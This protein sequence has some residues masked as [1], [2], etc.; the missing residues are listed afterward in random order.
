MNRHV[1]RRRWSLCSTS[2]FFPPPGSGRDPEPSRCQGWRLQWCA[3]RYQTKGRGFTTSN[4][5]RSAGLPTAS[6]SKRLNR[7]SGRSCRRGRASRPHRQRR[8]SRRTARQGLRRRRRSVP[9]AQI[10]CL[11]NFAEGVGAHGC[12]HLWG[13]PCCGRLPPNLCCFVLF[14]AGRF[15]VGSAAEPRPPHSRVD[16]AYKHW[17]H[18]FQKTE[19]AKCLIFLRGRRRVGSVESFHR[20]RVSSSASCWSRQRFLSYGSMKAALC[21]PPKVW[22]RAVATSS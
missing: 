1:I 20:S 4:A 12:T 11:N 17:P 10:P 3:L 9:P 21:A 7:I 14:C 22:P 16:P 5:Y 6:T 8:A 18:F 19:E 13:W 15:R 2:S